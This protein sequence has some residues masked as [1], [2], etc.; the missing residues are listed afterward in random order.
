M[1]PDSSPDNLQQ[2][3]ETA[4]LMQRG[5]LLLQALTSEAHAARVDAKRAELE[6]AI[7][8]AAAGDTSSLKLW[9]GG[10][11]S[12]AIPSVET[13]ASSATVSPGTVSPGTVSPGTV[14]Q[15][16]VSPGT[17]SPGT[18]SPG[19]VSPGT[20]SP[21]T[22][23][24][25]PVSLIAANLEHV[26]LETEIGAVTTANLKSTHNS[27]A[28]LAQTATT[29]ALNNWETLVPNSR[30]RLQAVHANLRAATTSAAAVMSAQDKLNASSNPSHGLA[31]RHEAKRVISKSAV[32]AATSAL[33]PHE[34]AKA[35][36][37]T[38]AGR[39]SAKKL[40]RVN[41]KSTAT[42][43]TPIKRELVS[44]ARAFDATQAEEHS[45]KHRK[46]LW[47]SG[48]SGLSASL[49]VH[50]LVVIVLMIITLQLPATTASLMFE[51][52]AAESFEE[53]LELT[54]PTEIVAAEVTPESPSEV[55]TDPAE[56]LAE[57]SPMNASAFAD[58]IPMQSNTLS[59]LAAAA[60]SGSANGKPN[61]AKANASFFGAAASGNSFCYVIDGSE[62]MRGGPWEAAK[63]EL[64]RSL[65]T[66]KESQKFYIVF[67]NKEMYAIS[68]PGERDP[69]PR[70]MYASKENLNHAR[71]WIETLRIAP[72][73]PPNKA[74]KFA[75][76]REPDAIYLLTDGDTKVDVAGY[77]R[78]HNRTHD[79]VSGE[80]VLVPIHAIAFY[81]Q[82]GEQ[83]M[84]LIAG[85]NKGQFI[86]VPKPQK[87]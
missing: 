9:L 51:S 65:A 59:N 23:S 41:A 31:P 35:G 37:S 10:N 49:L 66:L 24:P 86:Y 29:P 46:L 63:A 67:F 43:S 71:G 82:L 44:I 15:G 73:A 56:S 77:L 61:P 21:G 64:L 25:D 54:Q 75:I 1:E 87:K 38:A 19:T 62:S 14:S 58:N 4:M 84:K 52:S 30:R 80:Q 57:I 11:Q 53:A 22:V 8:N 2:P 3:V 12:K 69:A 5:R 34:G 76:E 45:Q 40:D 16:T 83:L 47:L 79:F 20:V 50:V 42:T 39:T 33:S 81:S 78:S 72:G 18:V 13:S 7:A 6:L 26:G 68:L 32:A 48:I 55:V 27:S 70:P 36:Q 28:G 74:L 60:A 17:V 85:E